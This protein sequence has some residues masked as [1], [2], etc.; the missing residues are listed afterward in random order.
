[1]WTHTDIQK[2]LH[3]LAQWVLYG[4]ISAALVNIIRPKP[5]VIICKQI[6]K[7]GDNRYKIKI[8]NQSAFSAY[9]IEGFVKYYD[10]VSKSE[11]VTSLTTK[12]LLGHFSILH[13]D[14]CELVTSIDPMQINE[15]KIDSLKPDSTLYKKYKEKTLT[16]EYFVSKGTES[17]IEI[18]L[19]ATH[20][21]SGIKKVFVKSINEVCLG[22]WRSGQRRFKKESR[23]T[24]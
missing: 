6:A 13:P 17:S 23:E 16:V 22:E 9:T 12:P 1:M 5:W 11:F 10:A 24:R 4:G 8:I 2:S 21:L 3:N 14:R 7:Y 20:S 18:I 15:E 19:S